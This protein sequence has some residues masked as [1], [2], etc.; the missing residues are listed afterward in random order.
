MFPRLRSL[1]TQIVTTS[2]H[3]SEDISGA[4]RLLKHPP[5][6]ELR[7]LQIV[8]FPDQVAKKYLSFDLGELDEALVTAAAD[9]WKNVHFS[10]AI[11]ST[12]DD[13]EGVVR[14]LQKKGLP[15]LHAKS[16]LDIVVEHG[17]HS[18]VT[19]CYD[20]ASLIIDNALIT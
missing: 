15:L 19:A 3:R 20:S 6:K 9:W 4:R 10:F 13:A 18:F 17:A 14:R 5:S 11:C 8:I 16:P 2:T 7:S 1:A 12:T